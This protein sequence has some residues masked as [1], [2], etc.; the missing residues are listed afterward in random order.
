MALLWCAKLSWQPNGSGMR[1]SGLPRLA[2]ILSGLGMLSGTLRNPSMSSLKA[3][4]R[5]GAPHE[6]GAE[7]FLERA[8]VRQAA[9]AVAG[10]EQHRGATRPAVGEPLDELHR[11]L[12]RPGLGNTGGGDQR[13]VEHRGA[14]FADAVSF[15]K[16]R[17]HNAT[18]R[19]MRRAALLACVFARTQAPGRL[20]SLAGL[21]GQ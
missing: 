11:L 5:V 3:T 17:C 20:R 15:R 4:R 16:P 1:L 21:P 2:V 14:P 13:V 7:D 19:P 9:W 8:D 6:R 12:K 10:L 18:G